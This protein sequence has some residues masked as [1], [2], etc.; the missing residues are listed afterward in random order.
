MEPEQVKRIIE[1]LIIASPKPVSATRLSSIVPNVT[2]AKVK[3]IIEVLRKEYDEEQRG[4]ELWT[5]AGGDQ[6]RTRTEFSPYVKQL[7][8]ERPLRLSKAALETLSIVA[9]KQPVTR[10]EIEAIRGV[11]AGA[12]VRSLLEKGLVK[13]AG[14]REVLGRP[15]EY[16]TSSRFLEVFGLRTLRDLPTLKDLE[17]ITEEQKGSENITF[18]ESKEPLADPTPLDL[19]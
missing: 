14:H 7:Q 6:V 13:G 15:M 17:E 2:V 10:G 12:V 19:H 18:D 1:A 4:F 16:A 3:E 11:D 5:I 9:Y 8:P